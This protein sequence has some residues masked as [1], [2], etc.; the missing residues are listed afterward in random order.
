MVNISSQLFSLLKELQNTQATATLTLTDATGLPDGV[1]PGDEL[2]AAVVGKLSDL[3]L[4]QV[5]NRLIRA[6]TQLP[7]QMG[8]ALRLR[9]V[10]NNTPATVRIL[11]R[12]TQQPQPSVGSEVRT[13]MSLKS[14][15][16]NVVPQIQS[17]IENITNKVS[18]PSN[19]PEGIQPTITALNALA[20]G[21]TVEPNKIQALFSMFTSHVPNAF[22]PETAPPPTIFMQILQEGLDALKQ[23]TPS[24][25]T[26]SALSQMMEPQGG[27]A[28]DVPQSAT[29]AA[30]MRMQSQEGLSAAQ[31]QHSQPFVESIDTQTPSAS[32][33]NTQPSAEALLPKT[34]V[35]SPVSGQAL[36]QSPEKQEGAAS[37]ARPVW[38]YEAAAPLERN[39]LTQSANQPTGQTSSQTQGQPP[40]Q[41]ASPIQGQSMVQAATQVPSQVQSPEIPVSSTLVSPAVAGAA[42][43]GAQA[44]SKQVDSRSV[45]ADTVQQAIGVFMNQTPEAEK[46]PPET[47]NIQ[48]PRLFQDIQGVKDEIHVQAQAQPALADTGKLMPQEG[49]AGVRFELASA[50]TSN[51]R[52]GDAAQ[53]TVRSQAMDAKNVAHTLN[54]LAQHMDRMQ[55]FRLE[56]QQQTGINFWFIPLWFNGDNGSGHMIWWKDQEEGRKSGVQ[57]D[58]QG[59]NLLFDLQLSRLGNLKIRLTCSGKAVQCS[60][61]AEKAVLPVIRSGIEELRTRLDS[62]GFFMKLVELSALSEADS[63][64][65]DPLGG[66][67]ASANGLL[68]IV[69]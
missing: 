29:P 6:R 65:F 19:L 60:V 36:I 17:L 67:V 56:L 39:G 54:L 34:V 32:F 23:Q 57:R 50:T 33:G 7:L 69:A 43:A 68:N 58:S 44:A 31:V 37:A 22:A 53:T 45:Q 63:K 1:M 55:T 49:R 14:V 66:T 25:E 38:L 13:F 41:T 61:A 16:L 26:P 42:G 12:L 52:I 59:Y 24:M 40:V 4:L 8:D 3:Y 51:D 46:I 62:A 21:D 15:L 18:S 35:D 9:V 48:Q 64:V 10:D 27:M 28:T 47:P 5:D 30:S 20:Q 11:E 2:K